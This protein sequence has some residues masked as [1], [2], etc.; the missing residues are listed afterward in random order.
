MT[1]HTQHKKSFHISEVNRRTGATRKAIHLY[2]SLG[3]LPDVQRGTNRYRV[4]TD[5]HIVLVQM[6]QRAQNVGFKLADL[7][8]L[9]QLKMQTD[10]FPVDMALDICKQMSMSLQ[11]KREQIRRQESELQALVEELEYLRD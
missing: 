4:Y 6:I 3:L 5:H 10:H 11:L 2:E 9:I 8:A 7:E 1:N